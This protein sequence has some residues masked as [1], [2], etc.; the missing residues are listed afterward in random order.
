M[1]PKQGDKII[2]FEEKMMNMILD[3][4]KTMEIRGGAIK[5]GT[6]WIGCKKN[7]TGKCKLSRPIHITTNDLWKYLRTKHRWD[8]DDLPYKK[9][10]VLKS[11]GGREDEPYT[12]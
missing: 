10:L 1:L 2:M 5:Q 3:G 6:Y 8:I 11:I 7:I 4:T 9:N 12:I